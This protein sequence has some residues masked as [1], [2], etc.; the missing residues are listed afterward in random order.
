MAIY[1]ALDVS[2][3][4]TAICVVD[5]D[6][7]VL[8]EG[9]TATC[10]DAITAW[11]GTNAADLKRLG[12]ETGPLAV[13][14]WNALTMRRLPVVCIDARHANAALKMMPN[15]TDRHDA[16]GLAQI[17]RTGWFKEVR[18]KSHSAYV[19]RAH[20]A[21]RDA[22][23]GTRV[24][25]ENEI[26]GLLKT[27]GVMFGRQ[28]GGFM[29]RAVAGAGAAWG[30]RGVDRGAACHPRADQGARPSDPCDCA[31]QPSRPAP[32]DGAWRRSDYG[33][34]RCFRLRRRRPLPTIRKRRRI[35]RAR[36][37]PIRVRRGQPKR[38]DLKAR[39]QD[40]PDASLRGGECDP[41]PRYR[42]R[43]STRLGAQDRRGVRI[44]EGEGRCR[45]QA[46]CHAARD[47]EGGHPVPRRGIA[48]RISRPT[49]SKMRPSQDVWRG[50]DR[51]LD[52]GAE[53]RDREHHFDP[54]NPRTPTCGSPS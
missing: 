50:Q 10:P 28:V 45:P 31:A 53:S 36:A 5:G 4:K 51:S 11:L 22:L 37:A 19:M 41:H 30:F 21:A 26:R 33:D 18:I 40:D 9:V 14:L 23:V 32:D 2:Q 8:K 52:C 24:R 48:N 16:I 47:V 15:K 54:S 43:R 42:R 39:R 44:Q 27:F 20:L 49:P 7:A 1:A 12:M 3:A 29:R 17:T 46:R 6:G 25:F 13:W 35:S 34:V 38:A